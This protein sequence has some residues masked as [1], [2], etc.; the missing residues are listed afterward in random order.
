MTKLTLTCKSFTPISKNSLIG[1]AD[2][3]IEQL[4]MTARGVLILSSNGKQWASLPSPAMLNK[5]GVALRDERGKI[6]YA[7]C[8]DF[9]SR[10]I[11]DAFSRACI[12]AVTRAFP[13]ALVE[14]ETI[15]GQGDMS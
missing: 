5:D 9:D 13:D 6:K 7:H 3:Y 1:K 15:S 8:F 10:E 4:R 2:I 11:R 14:V 12:A